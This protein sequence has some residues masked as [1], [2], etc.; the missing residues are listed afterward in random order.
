MSDVEPVIKELAS[1]LASVAR[2]L[3]TLEVRPFGSSSGS[4]TEGNGSRILL[5]H[6]N[7]S[8]VSEYTDTDIGLD[9][10]SAAAIGGEIISL[11]A[12]VLLGDHTLTD[13][14]SYIGVDRVM[15]ILSGQITLGSETI[16]VNLTVARISTSAD[17]LNIVGPI[18]GIARIYDCDLSALSTTG[19]PLL[20]SQLSGGITE[21]YYCKLTC[22]KNAV[23][24]NPFNAIG[25]IKVYG[26]EMAILSGTPM[27]GDRSA[28][29]VKN[30]FDLHSNETAML[31]HHTTPTESSGDAGKADILESE[32]SQWILSPDPMGNVIGPLSAQDLDF[33]LFDGSTGKKIRTL[34]GALLN[35]GDMLYRTIQT[36][37]ALTSL[38]A[39]AT[40]SR[41]YYSNVGQ[42]VIDGNPANEYFAGP[43]DAAGVWI[44]ID[45]GSAQ[46]IIGFQVGPMETN[47]I[48]RMQWSNDDSS[49][50]TARTV[51]SKGNTENYDLPIAINARYWRFLIVVDAGGWFN[52][53][54]IQ[55][56]SDIP[57]DNLH[58]GTELQVLT[59][60]HGLPA[61]RPSLINPMTDTGDLIM[62]G[63]AGVL[64][65][66]HKGTDGY[67]L[68]L[69]SGLP[70]WQPLATIPGKA[71][72]TELDTGTNDTK[73]ATAKAIKDAHNVPSVAPGTSGNVMKSDGTEWVSGTIAG[74]GDVVG[75][76]SVVDGHSV[77]FDGT[78]GKLIK[79]G[80]AV[81]SAV[82]VDIALNG[83][84]ALVVGIKGYI[85]IP[86]ILN[87]WNLVSVAAMC[88][89]ASSS[90]TP[91][92]MVKNG[93]T[94]MLTTD[95]TID[96]GEYD[97]DGAV[98][99][100][101]IDTDNDDVATGDRIEVVCSISGTDV[102]YAVVEL[103]FHLP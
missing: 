24:I 62:G 28:T 22:Q 49:W 4:Y 80:G 20:V 103:T 56:F 66:L 90:G 78:T 101:V 69:V 85:R 87:G 93:A 88:V 57:L 36:N 21:L 82:A 68:M 1:S 3:R 8:P 14:V 99:P 18:G 70:S 60:Y 64:V 38:G 72:G 95:L 31:K 13:G 65:V 67:I 15:S 76:A 59:V 91:T 41:H 84:T 83:E 40:D 43:G 16:L 52:L 10:A 27:P 35:P 100:A 12:G 54:E 29:D 75:P 5:Y 97:S 86:Q 61:W 51:T 33:A 7:G 74:T 89:I 9:G 92:F 23:D 58:I 34:G 50:V 25:E 53:Q 71:S 47:S 39:T 63:T 81:A 42:N 17:I 32:G 94:S 96:A 37:I 79:D 45:L 26:C 98:V 19:N 30:Y 73:F 44:R 46:L 77:I 6:I 48:Y 2:R 102:T 55:L 11:P